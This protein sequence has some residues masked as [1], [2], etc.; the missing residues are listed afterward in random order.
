MRTRSWRVE[1]APCIAAPPATLT[2]VLGA[3]EEVRELVRDPVRTLERSEINGPV[4]DGG[5]LGGE[6]PDT[7]AGTGSC[8]ASGLSE[9]A[10]AF[11]NAGSL[12][13][14]VLPDM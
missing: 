6:R 3:G 5:F 13:C 2:L 14:L 10:R 7:G 11:A 12:C 9:S 1:L 8:R 4:A